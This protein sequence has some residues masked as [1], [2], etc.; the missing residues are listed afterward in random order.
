MCLCFMY[1]V[2]PVSVVVFFKTG[3]DVLSQCGEV[4]VNS[5]VLLVFVSFEPGLA[6]DE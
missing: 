5:K 3:E 1:E 6:A 2:L 4:S